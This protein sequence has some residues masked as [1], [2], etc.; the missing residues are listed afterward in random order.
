MPAAVGVQSR[1]PW[2]AWHNDS[3][4]GCVRDPGLQHPRPVDKDQP[5]PVGQP[6][7]SKSLELTIVVELDAE[8]VIV[9]GTVEHSILP[10]SWLHSTIS[11][12]CVIAPDL[13]HPWP[14]IVDQPKPVGQPQPSMPTLV[15]AT[16][17]GLGC[18]LQSMLPIFDKQDC[19]AFGAVNTPDLQQSC[20][21][22]QPVPTGHPQIS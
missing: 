20:S 8:V 9:S 22:D 13:Q 4:A 7:T 16:V 10:R 17:D 3:S 12:G 11:A 5:V 14:V 1:L 2:F 6:H 21:A 18:T 15:V 19:A